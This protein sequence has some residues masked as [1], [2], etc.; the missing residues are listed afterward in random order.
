SDGDVADGYQPGTGLHRRLAEKV[1]YGVD[2]LF[3]RLQDD[4]TRV[5]VGPGTAPA[6]NP[7]LRINPAGTDLRR[8]DT[9]V[10]TNAVRLTA[11]YRF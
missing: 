9:D 11:T 2:Y 3:T 4:D 7:F 6:T 10:S 8:T 5:R 1:P